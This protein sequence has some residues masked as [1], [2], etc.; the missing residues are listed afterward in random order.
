MPNI[1]TKKVVSAENHES[2][3]QRPIKDRNA[4]KMRAIISAA[5]GALLMFPAI[6]SFFLH[7]AIATYF[8]PALFLL[9]GYFLY[10]DYWSHLPTFGLS[11]LGFFALIYGP[12]LFPGWALSLSLCG[13]A[14]IGFSFVGRPTFQWDEIKT[15]L[16]RISTDRVIVLMSSLSTLISL[17]HVVGVLGH[18]GHFMLH[19][20]FLA[21]GAVNYSAYLQATHKGHHFQHPVG[22]FKGAKIGAVYNITEPKQCPHKV[23]AVSP[24]HILVDE[25]QSTVES[26]Q[27]IE[28][29]TVITQGQ[30]SIVELSHEPVADARSEDK[31]VQLMFLGLMVFVALL[32]GIHGIMVHSALKG[33][34]Q[35]IFNISVMCPCV[36]L[37]TKPLLVNALFQ[38]FKE[39]GV[40]CNLAASV[41]HIDV[42]IF[43]RTHTLYHP[44]PNNDAFK[45]DPK[46]KTAMQKLKKAG[47]AIHIL[48]GHHTQG[49]EDHKTACENELHGIVDQ[50]TFDEKYHDSTQQ[51][52]RGYIEKLQRAGKKVCFVGDGL[53]DKLAL[54]QADL[55]IAMRISED[56]T[57]IPSVIGKANYCI[58]RS[59]LGLID[60][61]IDQST[62]VGGWMNLFSGM[63]LAYHLLMLSLIN[64]FHVSVFSSALPG[65]MMMTV[66]CMASQYV[67]YQVAESL[68]IREDSDQPGSAD[69][70]PCCPRSDSFGLTRTAIARTMGFRCVTCGATPAAMR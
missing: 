18:L 2:C 53:N 4:L 23:R 25:T 69:I 38:R 34:E 58:D 70:C 8:V 54:Q 16:M 6:E 5:M 51:N 9:M 48:S 12:F 39:H 44:D 14:A 36:F 21:I 20:A 59:K 19:E 3:C 32:S 47:K 55:S 41:S 11:F 64:V 49:W 7:G 29:H 66:F 13:V 56:A 30:V 42:V 1:V 50:V 26:G 62:K 15:G 65:I 22:D 37:V 61:I 43:D 52:K 40:D 60:Q 68:S 28:P 35:F 46:A 67:A 17:M 10:K 27:E 45:L 63:G 24:V 31:L 33:I 57:G